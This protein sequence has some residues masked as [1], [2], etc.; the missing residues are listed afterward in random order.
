[1]HLKT[2]YYNE[3]LTR[4]LGFVLHVA[5][6]TVVCCM[7][8][9]AWAGD[10]LTAYHDALSYDA[11][12]LAARASRDA[13]LERVPQA[14]AGLLPTLTA[15][16]NTM[17]NRQDSLI[18]MPGAEPLRTRYNSNG[19]TLQF[20]QPLFRWQNWIAYTQAE[21]AATAAELELRNAQQELMLRV[22]QAYFEML[23]AEEAVATADAQISAIQEQL[24]VA[25]KSF[26]V[27]TAT[28]TDT[29]EAQAR[30]DLA[31]AQKLTAESELLVKREALRMLTGK[32]TSALKRLRQHAAMRA[33]Q[34]D[35]AS[36]W[37]DRAFANNLQVL[38]RQ[39]SVEI[40]D[41]EIEKQKAAHLPTLDIVATHGTAATG[42]SIAYGTLRPG[43]DMETSTIGVQLSMPIFSGG[44][45]TSKTREAV[46]LKDKAL[47]ELDQARRKAELE[48]RESYLG[49]SSGLAQIRAYEAAM[50]SS[51]SSVD[52]NKLAF[53]YGVRINIDVLNAQSQLYETRQKLVKARIETLLAQLKLKSAVGDLSE[54]DL[55]AINGMLE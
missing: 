46:A 2:S 55:M 6:S 10:L 29:H 35:D 11:Q 27:G 47:A 42:N 16:A 38:L 7:T 17:S 45:T 23:L 52:S 15:N 54:D 43:T 39:R 37:A 53:K 12:Y 33:P 32:H 8:S 18:R 28:I 44:A 9:I 50:N 40:A 20:S 24:A 34:P 13:G 5:A 3:R 4:R 49:V 26:E 21:L 30:F 41:R 22:A 1:M 51:Q 31:N 48:T 14:R 36:Q 25:K 19:W